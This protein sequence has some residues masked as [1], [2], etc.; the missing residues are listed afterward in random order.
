MRNYCLRRPLPHHRLRHPHHRLRHPHHRL[1]RPLPHHPLRHP[2]GLTKM[3]RACMK[4]W[5]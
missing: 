3:C 1:R 5:G 4:I 2:L